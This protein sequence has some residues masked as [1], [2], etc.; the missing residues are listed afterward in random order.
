MPS[1]ASCSPIH[2]PQ[3]LSKAEVSLPG[4][5]GTHL[6]SEQVQDV[7]LLHAKSKELAPG[8]VEAGPESQVWQAGGHSLCGFLQAWKMEREKDLSSANSP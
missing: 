7:Q 3:G 5:P 2:T 4:T 6:K 8:S 1:E